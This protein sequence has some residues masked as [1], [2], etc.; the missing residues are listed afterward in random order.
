[1]NR[2]GDCRTAPATPVLLI[3]SLKLYQMIPSQAGGMG[4]PEGREEPSK[5]GGGRGGG[6]AERGGDRGARELEERDRGRS[7]TKNSFSLI[8]K[9]GRQSRAVS[10]VQVVNI[11]TPYSFLACS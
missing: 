5:D 10:P 4:F 6:G 2:K 1:M 7:R 3:I 11:Q 9:E 8:P